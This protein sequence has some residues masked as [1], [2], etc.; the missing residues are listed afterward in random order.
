ILVRLTIN[1]R[2][3]DPARVHLLP[4]LWFRNT[5]SWGRG[6]EDG[7]PKNRPLLRRG[8]S[9]GSFA[10]IEAEHPTLGRFKLLVSS[11]QLG[12]AP[13]LLFTENE[14]N[15]ERLFGSANASPFV[16]DAFHRYVIDQEEDAINSADE[17]TKAAALYVLDIDA[18]ESAVVHCRLVSENVAESDDQTEPD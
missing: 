6:G 13:R 2:G 1:N 14:T 9:R 7:Y 4:T 8:R 17:G 18:G 12:D 10:S 3:P 15:S 5:W 16:K 11:D